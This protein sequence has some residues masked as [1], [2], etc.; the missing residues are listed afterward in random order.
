MV[1]QMEWSPQTHSARGSVRLGTLYLLPTRIDLEGMVSFLAVCFLPIK[2]WQRLRVNSFVIAQ[3][4]WG[5]GQEKVAIKLLPSIVVLEYSN[6]YSNSRIFDISGF[7][8]ILRIRT[9]VV[10]KSRKFV[11]IRSSRGAIFRYYSN[12]EGFD[13]IRRPNDLNGISNKLQTFKPDW[14]K[15]FDYSIIR[16]KKKNWAYSLFDYSKS[17]L[18]NKF[19]HSLENFSHRIYSF[20]YSIKFLES[21]TMLFSNLW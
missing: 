15:I 18:A 9:S 10:L 1:Q 3:K 13:F 17:W 21:T 11:R 20:F 16:I 2:V 8:N 6:K 4:S 14:N 19:V 12:L 7:S 5:I